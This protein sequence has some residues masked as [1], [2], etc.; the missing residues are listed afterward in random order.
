MASDPASGSDIPKHML[1][2]PA[3]MPASISSR[4]RGETRSRTAEGPKAQWLM[5]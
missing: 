5:A 2:L 1:W 4:A 3:I